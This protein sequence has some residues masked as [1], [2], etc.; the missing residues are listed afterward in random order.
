MKAILVVT[1]SDAVPTFER[2]FVARQRGFTVIPELI[3]M[4]R[5]GLKA[6]DRIHPGGS[7]LLFSVV[8][9]EELGDTVAEL[10]QARDATVYA[11]HTRMWSFAVEEVA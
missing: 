4:G 11:E 10:K 2:A 5:S 1:D 7:S 8:P 9:D 6:G 3:G